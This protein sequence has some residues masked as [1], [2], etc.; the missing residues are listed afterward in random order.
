MTVSISKMSIDY[1]LNSAAVGDGADPVPDMTS[2]Y[3]GAKAPPG[4]WAGSGLVGLNLTAG[5]TVSEH[6][7]R[8]LFQ[9][10]VDPVTG[11][12]LGRPIMGRQQ[13]PAG[14]RTPA[15]QQVKSAREGV[16]GFDLTFSVPKSVS[17]LW[18][19]AGPELQGRIQDA[20]HQ[21]LAETLSWAEQ[22]VIQSRAGHGGVAHVPVHGVVASLFDHWDS[23]AG[24]PQLHTHAVISNRVQRVAD[25]QWVTIDSYTLHRHVVAIS[26]RYN[27]LL[28][29]RLH[30]HVGAVAESRDAAHDPGLES[31]LAEAAASEL[32]TNHAAGSR[33]RVEVSGVPDSLIHEFS[34]RSLLIEE[35]ADELI[36][37]WGDRHPDK[38]IPQAT[39]LQLRQQATLET[40]TP[41]TEDGDLTLSERMTSWRRRALG[42][43]HTPEQVV[44]TAVGHQAPTITAE[45]LTAGVTRQLGSFVLQEASQ[46]R[47]TFTRANI[48]ASAERVMRL[49]RCA[50]VDQR[51]NLVDTVVQEALDQAVALTPHRLTL[52]T[53]S[54]G[55]ATTTL[56]GESVFD[57]HRH[58]GVYTTDQVLDEEAY[59]LDRTTSGDAPTL[60]DPT[61]LDEQLSRWRSDK[62]LAL[63]SDQHAA[64]HHALSQTTG[65]SA[66]IGPAGTGKTT[67]MA[68]I[69]A[70][71]QATHGDRSVLGLAP[72]AVAAGGLAETIGTEAENVSKWLYESVGEGAA[73]RAEKVAADEAR[74]AALISAPHDSETHHRRIETL[75]ARLA[76]H[77]ATQAHYQLRRD[78]LLI[79][80]ESSMIS[81]AQLAEL[82]HQ[83]ETA[84]AK[85]LMVGDPAQLEAVDAGGFLGH[86][87]RNLDHAKL[88]SVFRF[89]QQWERQASLQLRRGDKDALETYERQGRLHGD[90]DTDP[91]DAAYAAWEAD[92]AAGLSSILIASDNTTVAELN[93][94]AQVAR[95]VSGEVD[96]ETTVP[97]R[98]DTTAGVGDSILARKNNRALRDSAGAFVGNGTLMTVEQIHPD[99]SARARLAES[100]ATV[101]LD[102]D[103]LA[104][105]VELGYA[106]TAHRSQGV[107]VDT[108]HAVVRDDLSRELFYVSMTRGR[109]GNHAYVALADEQDH[110]PDQW[111]LLTETSTAD[112][113]RE[114]LGP[115][116]SRSTAERTAHEARNAEHGWAN[117]LG[118]L[119]H[120]AAYLHW[121]ARTHRTRQWVQNTYPEAT[122][123]DIYT[124]EQWNALAGADPAATHTGQTHPDDS[125]AD[126][127]A[128]CQ[129]RAHHTTG[130]GGMLPAGAAA[131]DGQ[132]QLLE[133]IHTDIDAQLATRIHALRQDPPDW[134]T[135][136]ETAYPDPAS[137]RD[138]VDAVVTWRAVSE[139]GDADTA[140][141][142]E[143]SERDYLRPFWQR[144]QTT[145]HTAGADHHTETASETGPDTA[146]AAAGPIP[147]PD[148]VALDQ[149]PMTD[150]LRRHVEHTD[151]LAAAHAALNRVDPERPSTSSASAAARTPAPEIP[152]PLDPLDPFSQPEPASP[153]PQDSGP[154]LH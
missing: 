3:T 154:D 92:T 80:D 72:S 71:W 18:A 104:T 145:L 124:D 33:H 14:A 8:A 115:V 17:A 111:D 99:G 87:E 100:G 79:L 107:T 22:N 47:S 63:S 113:A 5:E 67:T 117:D 151:T 141:G 66:I 137:R 144:L 86:V 39:V 31:A 38:V 60:E 2:Y 98:Q 143:P 91:A 133:S 95:A 135:D 12:K 77:Y 34:T 126:I 69:T 53:P 109:Q 130:P 51:L 134:F 120:E 35:R 52:T 58:A 45:M 103:Y 70:T 32:D 112:T 139:Q 41:K 74:L 43:G 30:D 116:V 26:E 61:D 6:H 150:H 42:A 75:Q 96:I 110:G 132:A 97:L 7:A 11:Q 15:G 49:V 57:H 28:F 142:D 76:G 1:Y 46:R 48:I 54:P 114:A 146:A 13:T 65:I 44:R 94:R 50:D 27:S 101:D 102:G 106:T 78:Q 149:G 4:R 16:A 119:C 88:T 148:D 122:A 153:T 81:T 20:H 25:D 128:R 21:A 24:D 85:V 131:T 136:L 73:R 40:R 62:G 84:G 68:A 82:A 19:L 121:A 89:H 147:D 105:S 29:D 108:G 23:R 55:D 125:A 93:Q 152:D 9:D 59:L 83:A 90:K 138:V 140:L 127:L 123:S 10:Q 118:R 56:R 37:A 36:A 64:A 129:S